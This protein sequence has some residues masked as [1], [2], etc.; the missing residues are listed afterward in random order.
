MPAPFRIVFEQRAE[1][2]RYLSALVPFISVL[3]AL[4]AGALFLAAT[5]YSPTDAYKHLLND[6]FLSYQG[7]TETMGI[8]TVLICTG[9]AAAFSF[10]MN[11]YNIG[12]EG[13]LYLGMI[14]AAWAGLSLGPHLP[15]FVMIPL[16]FVIGAVAGALWIFI[17][18][19][20]RARL[21]SSEIVTT[22]LLTY[23]GANL[24]DHFITSP[25]SF[26]KA[27][28][29]AFAQGRTVTDSARLTP[30]GDTSLYPTFFVVIVLALFLY[31]VVSRTEFGYRIQVIADSPNAARYAGV[32]AEKTTVTVM[33]IS[34]A[35]AG[36][37][38]TTLIVGPYGFLDQGVKILGYGY[39]GIVVATLARNNFLGIVIS[40]I[41]FAGLR[42]GGENLQIVTDTP[43]EI[44]TILQGAI[45]LFVLGGETFRR[46]RIRMIKSVGV[47]L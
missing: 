17:P 19:F 29:S 26:F 12:G 25:D 38:G 28:G 35:L 30:L 36:I 34:G 9:I 24:I 3:A 40:G 20:V 47:A 10:Q 23:V 32:N 16:M 2:P 27:K 21:G 7:I 15:S 43:E 13:Q 4:L 45:L 22:L 5:G 11:L 1:T 46:Y 33:L 37:A 8:S 14:G 31:W 18:A 42:V 41:L 44:S 6:G 39:A